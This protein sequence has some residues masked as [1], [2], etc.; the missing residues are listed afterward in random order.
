MKNDLNQTKKQL[1]EK[2]QDFQNLYKDY[3]I[4]IQREGA[5]LFEINKS[6]NILEKYELLRKENSKLVD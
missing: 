3:E 6:K 1:F 2:N 4:S 5:Y